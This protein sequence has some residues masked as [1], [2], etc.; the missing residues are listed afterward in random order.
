MVHLTVHIVKEIQFLG[1]VFLHQMYPFERF[2]G[3][4]KKYVRNR[5]RPEGSIAEGWGAEE[6]IEFCIDY[7]DLKPI[8]L[9]TSRHEGRLHGKGTV[10]QKSFRT[11]DRALF[12]QAHFTVL[13]HS[14]V[15]E[16]YERVHKSLLRKINPQRPEAWRER[17]H[18]DT[19]GDWL[20][21]HMLHAQ[22]NSDQLRAL[23]Q[24]PSTSILSF[25]AYEI[26]GYTFYTRSQD[27]KTTYQN[28][29]VR[30]DAYDPNNELQTY[31][32]FIEEIW[33]LDYGPLKVPLF[34]CQWVSL[35]GGVKT[36]KYGH[37][38]VD[39]KHVGY[40]DE[41]F[42][43]ANA[44]SQIFFVTDPSNKQRH[45]VVEGKRSIVGVEDVVDEEE[46]NR[47]DDFPPFTLNVDLNALEDGGDEA[48]IRLDHNEGRIV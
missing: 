46:Y 9:P 2:M 22:T 40:R 36:D 27:N 38:C 26:N 3:V 37:T 13:H 5:N 31:Y 24:G 39:L 21:R 41:P 15:A 20:L 35:P 28:S 23:S 48:Y 43:L 30:I 19:F 16:E 32:G 10:G 14:V 33:E 18:R 25:Q 7:M 4:I 34:R 1:L 12:T 45:V 47:F 17:E 8:G 6:V 29:G 44:V 42:V 11:N